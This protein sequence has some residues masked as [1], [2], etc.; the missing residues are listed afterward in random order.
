MKSFLH[1]SDQPTK[2]GYIHHGSDDGSMVSQLAAR[3]R[4][5]LIRL[6][7]LQGRECNKKIKHIQG[8]AK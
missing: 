7:S 1:A 4:V 2:L 8:A 5:N 3:W 6:S